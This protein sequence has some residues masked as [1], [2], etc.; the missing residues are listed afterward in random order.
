MLTRT[1]W[2]ENNKERCEWCS[3]KGNE[4]RPQQLQ[5]LGM[6]TLEERRHQADMQIVHKIG[7]AWRRPP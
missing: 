7:N 1:A 2:K 3:I 6:A 5:E 4:L